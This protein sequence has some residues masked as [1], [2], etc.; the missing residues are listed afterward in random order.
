MPLGPEAHYT[1][2]RW[3]GSPLQVLE[4]AK[5]NVEKDME[6]YNKMVTINMV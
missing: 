2:A 1:G 3:K 5:K 4:A 6:I